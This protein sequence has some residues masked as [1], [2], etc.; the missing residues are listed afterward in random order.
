MSY[1]EE[2][3]DL[4]RGRCTREASFLC[5]KTSLSAQPESVDLAS[6]MA[7]DI[8]VA[9]DP[10][11]ISSPFGVHKNGSDLVGKMYACMFLME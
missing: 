2:R 10:F 6:H 8:H 5:C 4:C 3:V 1:V 7:P 9:K 11:M